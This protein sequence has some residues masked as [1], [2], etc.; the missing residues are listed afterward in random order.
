[1]LSVGDKVCY[2]PYDGCPK[3]KYEEGIVKSTSAYT[4]KVFVVYHCDGNWEDYMNYTGALTDINQ[5]KLGW[6]DGTL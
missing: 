1:M 2:I 5:L 4:T 3:E 6:K